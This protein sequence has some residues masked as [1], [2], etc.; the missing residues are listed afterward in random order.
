MNEILIPIATVL[1][2]LIV[3]LYKLMTPTRTPKKNAKTSTTYK[4]DILMNNKNTGFD[5]QEY[6]QVLS[7]CQVSY[8]G[9][10]RNVT[11]GQ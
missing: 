6:S 9:W 7:N 4:I 5:L 2:S 8:T 10:K 11:D 3:C 1:I